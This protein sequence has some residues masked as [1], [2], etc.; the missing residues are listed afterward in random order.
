MTHTQQNII[1]IEISYGELI[2]K[3]TILEI[4]AKRISNPEKLLNVRNE[5]ETLN[6]TFREQIEQSDE[7]LKLKKE[8]KMINEKLWGLEDDIRAKERDKEFG[9]EF[10]QLARSVYIINDERGRIK[11]A[12]NKLLGSRLIEEKEYTKY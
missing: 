6:K 12:I 8:L 7:L 9:I 11:R 1:Y 4:K 10:I 3:I 2:D 5:L